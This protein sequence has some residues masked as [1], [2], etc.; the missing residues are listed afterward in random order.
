MENQADNDDGPCVATA[1][2]GSLISYRRA[3]RRTSS[4]M[5]DFHHPR[6]GDRLHVGAWLLMQQTRDARVPRTGLFVVAGLPAV[7]VPFL[8]PGSRIAMAGRTPQELAGVRSSGEG[9]WPAR[10][11]RGAES[12]PLRDGCDLYLVGL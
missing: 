5:I 10:R 4:V 7:T 2:P 6:A 11:N 1:S 9:R 12:F 3:R 8:S